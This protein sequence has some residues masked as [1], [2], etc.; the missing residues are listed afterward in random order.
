MRKVLGAT[1][2]QVSGLLMKD[3]LRLLL[4]ANVF[5][6]PLG[7]LAMNRWLEGFAYRIELSPLIF[8]VGAFVV[9]F[10]ALLIVRLNA[11]KVAMENPVNALR[12]E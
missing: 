4:I 11:S 9:F 5:A 7:Y 2:S 3:L 6:I 10:I 8:L 12:S 1:A